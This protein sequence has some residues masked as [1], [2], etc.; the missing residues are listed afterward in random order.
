MSYNYE[1]L[2]FIKWP[3]VCDGQ[4]KKGLSANDLKT[5][6][7]GCLTAVEKSTKHQESIVNEFML[8]DLIQKELKKATGKSKELLVEIASIEEEVEYGL[9]LARAKIMKILDSGVANKLS[10]A[11]GE[12]KIIKKITINIKDFTKIPKDIIEE[13]MKQIEA[14]LAPVLKKIQK[15]GITKIPGLGIET[16]TKMELKWNRN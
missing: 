10:C 12:V 6:V 3:R 1:N 14:A 9:M 11:L 15:A 7:S 2:L 13:R 4:H 8:L 5:I 16:E